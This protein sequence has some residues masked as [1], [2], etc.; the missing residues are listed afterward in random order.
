MRNRWSGV[1]IDC[2]DPRRVALFWS[3]LLG[4][5][6][7]HSE[8]GWVYLGDRS[9]VLPRLVFQP[10]SEPKQGR[11]GSTWTSPSRTSPPG[12]RRS[13]RWVDRS[14]VSGTTTRPVSL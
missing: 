6:E 2:V 10:V 1:T 12:W 13:C 4:R 9:D 8:P 3:E 14:P 11:P 7:G 5:E